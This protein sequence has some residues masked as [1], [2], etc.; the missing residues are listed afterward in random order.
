MYGALAC[1]SPK[2]KKTMKNIFCAMLVALLCS[3]AISATGTSKSV[4]TPA[5]QNYSCL[6][7]AALNDFFQAGLLQTQRELGNPSAQLVYF[8]SSGTKDQASI[9]AAFEEQAAAVFRA[10]LNR[11]CLVD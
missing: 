5:Y 4:S 2:G 10:Y 7:L 8:T 6:Q 11:Q 3:P 9:H 1:H